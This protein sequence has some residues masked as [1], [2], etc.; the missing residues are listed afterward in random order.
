MSL[1]RP[2]RTRFEC[3]I[4]VKLL[5]RLDRMVE[6][7][8]GTQDGNVSRS[9][10]VLHA[11]DKH[12]AE[13]EIAEYQTSQTGDPVAKVWERYLKTV[14][15]LRE[16]DNRLREDEPMRQ[17]APPFAEL[18]DRR[19]KRLNARILEFGEVAVECAVVG[20]VSTHGAEARIDGLISSHRAMAE[21]LGKKA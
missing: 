18:T 7:L 19:R 15:R 1:K 3:R 21:A 20:Y 11:V 4:P 10:I 2:E 14:N 5:E 12:I 8:H 16:N 13:W 6:A 9:S 17:F